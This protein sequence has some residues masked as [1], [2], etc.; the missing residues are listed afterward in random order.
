MNWHLN[1]NSFN[2]L[3]SFQNRPTNFRDDSFSDDNYPPEEHFDKMAHKRTQCQYECKIQELEE[4]NIAEG[5]SDR[6]VAYFY[7]IK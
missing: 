2:G 3:G 7:Q 1:W 5:T 4:K 6:D